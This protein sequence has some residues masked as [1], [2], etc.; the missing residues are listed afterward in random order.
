MAYDHPA[1]FQQTHCRIL[2]H[3]E[4]GPNHKILLCSC[5]VQI[6]HRILI[7]LTQLGLHTKIYVVERMDTDQGASPLVQSDYWRPSCQDPQ[8]LRIYRV[9]RRPIPAATITFSDNMH[10]SG[11]VAGSPIP[12]QLGRRPD[13]IV[14]Q[15]SAHQHSSIVKVFRVS[16]TGFTG[17]FLQPHDHGHH[18]SSSACVEIYG[19]SY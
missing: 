15:L 14:Q 13:S 7:S 3:L 11:V 5:S 2:N 16:E 6:Q 1:R 17:P 9:V 12:A 10:G 19:G 18:A 8:K 4:N